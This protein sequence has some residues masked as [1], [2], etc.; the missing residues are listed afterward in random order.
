MRTNSIDKKPWTSSVV[1]GP[2]IF[3]KTMAVGPFEPFTA[4]ATVA[5]PRR[6]CNAYAERAGVVEIVEVARLAAR[7]RGVRKAI[8][9]VTSLGVKFVR[10]CYCRRMSRMAMGI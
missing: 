2:P 1:D 7:A 9:K 6:H 5:L 8:V 3:I 4:G 10:C